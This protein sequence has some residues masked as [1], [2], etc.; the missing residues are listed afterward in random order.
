MQHQVFS[1]VRHDP[2]AG[3]WKAYCQTCGWKGVYGSAR[4]AEKA[5]DMH[6]LRYK[7]AQ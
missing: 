3:G 2:E 6:A 1:E 7:E 5:A 4:R